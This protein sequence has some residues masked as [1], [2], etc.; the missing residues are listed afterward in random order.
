M[1]VVIMNV[2]PKYEG[3]RRFLQSVNDAAGILLWVF[4]L[5]PLPFLPGAI[6]HEPEAG[7]LFQLVLFV[8]SP[9]W[10]LALLGWCVSMMTL[11]PKPKFGI[12][13]AIAIIIL[14]FIAQSDLIHV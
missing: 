14:L 2:E 11:K 7:E 12:I 4:A 1:G 9:I 6:R 10:G 13:P 5:L 3:E 8:S